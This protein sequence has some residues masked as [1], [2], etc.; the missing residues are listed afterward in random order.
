MNR[1]EF[2]TLCST[3]GGAAALNRAFAAQPGKSNA[4][5]P[6][7]FP[8]VAPPKHLLTVD[9][10]RGLSWD[11][12]TTLT[13]FQ[14]LVNRSAPRIYLVGDDN[15]RYWL[16]YYADEYGISHEPAKGVE[17]LLG[18][19]ASEIDGYVVY[20]SDMLDSANVATTFGAV[21]NLVPVS[22][23]E[24]ELLRGVGLEQRDDFT[25][26]WP[27]QYTAYRWALDNLWPDCNH[28]LF[29]SACVDRPLWPS[30]S[31]WM[32]D[33]AMAHKLFTFDLSACRRDRADRDLLHTIFERNEGLGCV[34][35]WRC[36]RC[37]EHEFVE[38][39][40]RSGVS[41][42]CALNT[43]NL[44][45]HAAIPKREAPFEQHH[46]SKEEAR[47]VE[48]KVYISFMATDGDSL[49]SMMRLQS[50][51]FDD[52]EHGDLPFSY[53]F[54]PCAWDLMPGV[55]AANYAHKKE[56]DYFVVPSSGAMYTYPYFQRDP[57]AYMA[58]T[59]GYLD[60]TDLRAAYMINWNDDLYWQDP[61]VP[62]ILVQLR[63][64]LPE[65]TGFFQGQ[66]ESAFEPQHLGGGI[67]YIFSGE[68]LH[69]NS[70][71]A[72]TFAEFIAANPI[73][74][75]FIYC[76]TNHTIPL[77]RIKAGLAEL[78][79]YD[80]DL[81]RMDEFLWL[82]EQAR[83]Q[84]LI[85]A[86]NFY[87]NKSKLQV[88]LQQEAE[89][90]WQGQVATINAHAEQARVPEEEFLNLDHDDVTK[91][92]L[93]RTATPP[94]DVVAFDAIYDSMWLARLALNRRGIYVNEKAK[95]VEDFMREFGDV[96]EAEVMND[97]WQLW[98]SWST[99][100]PSYAEAGELAKR[101]DV[102]AKALDSTGEFSIR[103][104]K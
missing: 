25:G 14:G 18:H 77:G 21:R 1:R 69:S 24:V 89:G 52:P 76:L 41:A 13:C 93:T 84:E 70:D 5:A 85:P 15:D 51:R 28:R 99:T 50:G 29:A 96:K 3:V 34:L 102:L 20:D 27:D 103:A 33:Y 40:A 90:K 92:I 98:D 35:G 65:C 16:D 26:S 81:V 80:I 83:E 47:P 67:P 72:A 4:V 44:T 30:E 59:R 79:D 6:D 100:K 57:G 7:L 12:A 58:L 94:A 31:M 73:R 46:C 19:F 54:L 75:L 42:L 62:E 32:R 101:L 23:A 104:D 61:N 49:F 2:L 22:Q 9:L 97:L 53:G 8:E 86:N 56:N 68:G 17:D 74:P 60:K 63:R 48:K 38:V 91:V 37:N 82:V 55:A 88:L 43:R 11:M 64:G 71:V 66:G 10:P 87:P 78:D 36:V 45:V 39:A 95:G